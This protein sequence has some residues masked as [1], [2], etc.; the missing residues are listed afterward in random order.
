M[1]MRRREFLSRAGTASVASLI[2]ASNVCGG[3]SASPRQQEVAAD[4]NVR[5]PS[6]TWLFFDLW[7]FDH[8]ENIELRQGQPQWQRDATYV[9]PHIGN[10]S[11]WPTVYRDDKSGQWRMLYSAKWK[12]YSLMVAES[13]DGR[14]WRPLPQAGITPQGGKLAPHHL[15][16]LPGG[17]GGGVYLD[18]IASDG[19]PFKIF[20][21]QQ[22][23]P[24]VARAIADPKHRWHE[25]ARREG[26]KR[27]I[28]DEF[29]LVSRDGLRWEPRLDMKWSLP[30]WHPEPPIFGFYNRHTKKHAMTVRPGWGERRLCL[31]TTTDF[32]EWS[33]PELHLQPDCLDRERLELYGM[34]VFPYGDG[35]VGL[36]W[37][38]HC[39]STEPTRGFNRFV[40]PLDC[41]LAYSHDGVRFTRGFRE[42]FIPTNAL[43]EHGGGAIEPSCLV[44]TED[45]IRIYSS[46]S[47]VHHGQ[48]RQARR[49][50]V[51]D[52]ASILLHTLRKDGFMYLQSQGDW[53]RLISKPMVLLEPRL[54]MNAAAPIG[55]VRFQL[56]DMESRPVEGFTF[57]DC[58]PIKSTDS[59][60]FK[61]QWKG[62]RLGD[63]LGRIVRVEVRLRHANLYAFRGHFHFIDAQDRWLIE[64][65]KPIAT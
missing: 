63:I 47:K 32:R 3:E 55:E 50:G 52:A 23:E 53:G 34:P 28:N 65:G 27:Y 62:G 57:D 49:D 20:V 2:V 58:S 35:F 26:V 6:K 7:H 13:D 24:A 43:G 38:F 16:T 36:L 15:F 9:E 12:P 39:E 40:G 41:Q 46:A 11:A 31:Q 37:I 22:G 17:S 60:A 64:D 25:I 42:P 56:T 48:S 18:P 10:L 5:D 45:E 4:G 30:D 54:T 44:E 33:G 1:K 29:T 61:M 59:T 19:F 51:A 21:H 8:I 14:K